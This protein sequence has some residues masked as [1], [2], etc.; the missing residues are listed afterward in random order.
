MVI[1]ALVGVPLVLL[2]TLALVASRGARS[3]RLIGWT[4]AAVG[5]AALLVSLV[6]MATSAA[7]GEPIG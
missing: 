5:V 4:V 6:S 2:G 7:L 3:L 1:L